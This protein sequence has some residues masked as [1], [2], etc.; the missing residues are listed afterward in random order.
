MR[1][2]KFIFPFIILVL[3]VGYGFQNEKTDDKHKKNSVHPQVIKTDTEWQS[4]L[5]PEAFRVTRK[6]GT[7]SPFSG[8]YWNNKESGDYECLCCE[9][10][11]FSSATKYESG[12]GWPSFYNVVSDSCIL[13]LFDSNH[14][15]IRT[16]VTCARCNAHLGHVFDDGPAPT[17]LRY[18]I[19]SVSLQFI[20][21]K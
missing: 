11:L 7:E 4:I 8:K 21:N 1:F 9:L 19:N 6:T 17:G 18:C 15:W 2:N 14:G 5:S 12:T 16:E 10:T 3:I 20:P 13:Q